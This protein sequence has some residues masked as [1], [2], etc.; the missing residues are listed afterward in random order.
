MKRIK[1]II[2]T[3]VILLIVYGFNSG[4]KDPF[5]KLRTLNDVIRKVSENYVEEVDMEDVLNGA[6]IGMLDKLDPHSSFIPIE[7]ME[8]INNLVDQEI[9][10]GG[11]RQLR[12]SQPQHQIN[13][14]SK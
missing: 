13:G 9:L 14:G 12:K 2:L 7:D 8:R 5:K 6:F 4:A 1:Y 11:R 10:D 3:T